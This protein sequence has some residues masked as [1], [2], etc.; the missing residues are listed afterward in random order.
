MV[1]E[2]FA[3]EILKKIESLEEEIKSLKYQSRPKMQQLTELADKKEKITVFDV[4]ISLGI[5]R[6][7]ALEYMRKLTMEGNNFKLIT[8][9][10]QKGSILVNLNNQSKEKVVAVQIIEEMELGTKIKLGEIWERY[11]I[12]SREEWF[13]IYKQMKAMSPSKNTFFL[14]LPNNPNKPFED[15]LLVRRR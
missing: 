8:G 12:K 3:Q 14:D 5:S 9:S 15:G 2:A 10:G 13:D 11:G 4:Q 1:D 7:M 6:P